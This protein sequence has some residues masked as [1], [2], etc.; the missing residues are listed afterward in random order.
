MR[1]T[2]FVCASIVAG[3]LIGPSPA[4]AQDAQAL[5]QEIDQL[6][7]DFETLKQ[8]Y[9][10]RLT[11]LEAKLAATEG[12]PPPAPAAAA[13]PGQQPSAQVPAGAAGAGGPSGSLPVY[14]NTAAA[15]KIFNPDM[16]VIGDFLGA[17][18]KNDVHPD[19]FGPGPDPRA[20]QMHES[21]ASFQAVVDPYARGDFFLSFGEEGVEMEEGYITFTSLP[22]GLVTRVGNMRSG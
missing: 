20:L 9:G 18:G 3:L 19:P 5:R 15:S 7:R 17:V 4:F 11:A 6:R 21:E 22:G 2:R 14:G 13:Q 8:Q 10:D 12:T 1:A 16:A